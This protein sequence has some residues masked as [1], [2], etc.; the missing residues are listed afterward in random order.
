MW[1]APHE[2]FAAIPEAHSTDEPRQAGSQRPRPPWRQRPHTVY[3]HKHAVLAGGG[4]S[5]MVTSL[6]LSIA[7]WTAGSSLFSH[8]APNLIA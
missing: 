2:P 3:Y 1:T 5:G 4:P 7:A 8:S 6:K